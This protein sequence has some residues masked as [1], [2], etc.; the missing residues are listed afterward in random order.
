MVIGPIAFNKKQAELT[1]KLVDEALDIYQVSLAISR[2]RNSIEAS[3][4]DISDIDMIAEI[5]D[6]VAEAYSFSEFTCDDLLHLVLE[7]DQEQEA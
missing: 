6:Q 7:V 2:V 4:I 3:D 1:K 5:C